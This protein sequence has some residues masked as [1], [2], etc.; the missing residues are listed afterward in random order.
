MPILGI[1]KKIRQ[2]Q[3]VDSVPS[4]WQGDKVLFVSAGGC[5]RPMVDRLHVR[6]TK[7]AE[8]A[9]HTVRAATA[10]ASFSGSREA[11]RVLSVNAQTGPI[12]H[13]DIR[14]SQVTA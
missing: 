13:L 7:L 12:L 2:L 3:T 11:S 5:C 1:T 4:P 14:L 6:P 10:A 9:F 8:Y